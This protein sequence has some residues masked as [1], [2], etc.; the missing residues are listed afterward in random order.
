M[1]H[2]YMNTHKHTHTHHHQTKRDPAKDRDKIAARSLD[3]AVYIM[4]TLCECIHPWRDR[5]NN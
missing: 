1:A 2:T 5:A 4:R 3:R